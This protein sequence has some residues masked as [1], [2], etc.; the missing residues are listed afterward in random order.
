MN[1]V[2]I[3][4]VCMCSFN[5]CEALTEKPDI[6]SSKHFNPPPK[7]TMDMKDKYAR[8]P[9]KPNYSEKKTQKKRPE[10]VKM[11]SFSVEPEMDG[12]FQHG[13]E[14]LLHSKMEAMRTAQEK[15]E[16]EE[17]AMLDI[18]KR[19]M[20]L[21]EE[22]EKKQIK[23]SRIHQKVFNKNVFYTLCSHI[24]HYRLYYLSFLT[25][26]LFLSGKDTP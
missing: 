16:R 24:Y 15:H 5:L 18:E 21:E 19:H 22:E 7:F 20:E 12:N 8:M 25:V 23:E 11:P 17:K 13:E 6:G 26:H 14:A 3:L 1:E 2:L 4:L 10:K 9:D